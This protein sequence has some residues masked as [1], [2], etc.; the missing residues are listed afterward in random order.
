MAVPVRIRT[1]PTDCAFAEACSRVAVS[2]N[3]SR[4]SAAIDTTASSS[5]T[6]VRGKSMV[7]VRS[8]AYTA[9]LVSRA[10]NTAVIGAGAV[11]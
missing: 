10:A 9:T 4:P 11:G 7:W 3:R 6:P 1:S 2:G 8:T 5:H